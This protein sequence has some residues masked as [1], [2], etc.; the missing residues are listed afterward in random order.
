VIAANAPRSAS[1]CPVASPAAQR[2]LPARVEHGQLDAVHL[3]AGPLDQLDHRVRRGIEVGAA[4][5]A[6]QRRVEGLAQPVQDHRPVG[7]LEQLPVHLQVVPGIAGAGGQRPARHQDHPGDPGPRRLHE[8]H[9][10][11]VGADDFGDRIALPVGQLVGARPAG[12]RGGGS[13][14]TVL[15]RTGR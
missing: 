1:L 10:L 3:A 9:L 8:R 5:V 13:G 6:A 15:P 2:H 7:L 4:P 11:G 12:Q 14:R